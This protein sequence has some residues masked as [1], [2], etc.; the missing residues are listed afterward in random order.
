M[1]S[2]SS[3]SPESVFVQSST[4][5]LSQ[6]NRPSTFSSTDEEQQHYHQP[7]SSQPFN[8]LQTMIPSFPLK[9]HAPQN[10]DPLVL[11]PLSMLQLGRLKTVTSPQ[12]ILQSQTRSSSTSE[13]ENEA[14]KSQNNR[15]LT[16]APQKRS[17]YNVQGQHHDEDIHCREKVFQTVLKRKVSIHNNK[18]TKR[19]IKKIAK[20][21]IEDTE[22]KCSSP[23]K[24]KVKPIVNE[25]PEIDSTLCKVCGEEATKYIHYGGRSCASCRAFFRRSVESAKR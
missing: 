21:I 5:S 9:V 12:T 25:I 2:T 22:M 19:N 16:L 10:N 23:R 7:Q 6:N 15:N 8:V 14:R 4:P 18:K 20:T 1:Y 13:T 17:S 11:V 3:G 24:S